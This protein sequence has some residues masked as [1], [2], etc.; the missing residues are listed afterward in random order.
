MYVEEANSLVNSHHNTF[1]AM[2]RWIASILYNSNVAKKDRKTPEQ[3]MPLPMDKKEEAKPNVSRIEQ[4]A[5]YRM[6]DA[7]KSRTNG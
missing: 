5:I 2:Q 6:L 7:A 3:L 1:L 4:E